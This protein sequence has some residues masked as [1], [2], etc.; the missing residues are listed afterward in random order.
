MFRPYQYAVTCTSY[1]SS[2]VFS[3]VAE[4]VWVYF[5]VVKRLPRNDHLPFQTKRF[6]LFSPVSSLV[7]YGCSSNWLYQDGLHR[8]LE[9]RTVFLPGH[10]AKL[11][12]AF[13][14]CWCFVGLPLF[15]FTMLSLPQ[16]LNGF[17]CLLWCLW[18]AVVLRGENQALLFHFSSE[19]VI[20]N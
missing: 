4:T 9:T 11:S 16:L 2:R 1:I 6:I 19:I 17:F 15:I 7:T 13:H 5:W 20:G 18:V 12:P 8:P 10:L 3:V 14:Q